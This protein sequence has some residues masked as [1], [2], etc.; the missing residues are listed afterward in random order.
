MTVHTDSESLLRILENDTILRH[1]T[2]WPYGL[3]FRLS[4]TSFVE[5]AQLRTSCRR[6]RWPTSHDPDMDDDDVTQVQG[7]LCQ[8]L[9][10]AVS[11]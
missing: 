1:D 8:R 4:V 9:R 11:M 3:N 7:G 6:H 5:L 10:L 2:V